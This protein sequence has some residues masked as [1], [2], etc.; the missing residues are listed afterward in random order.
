MMALQV[1]IPTVVSTCLSPFMTLSFSDGFKNHRY[2][3]VDL[4]IADPSST[5]SFC[6]YYGL[7]MGIAVL[8]VTLSMWYI[9]LLGASDRYEQRVVQ[10]ID[11][12]LDFV[13]VKYKVRWVQPK[14]K[15]N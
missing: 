15:S 1:A 8:V 5:F 4:S 2:L 10:K 7:L 6:F 12:V 3:A 9:V 13:V 14:S 11:P